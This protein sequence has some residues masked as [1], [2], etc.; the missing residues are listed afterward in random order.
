[1]KNDNIRTEISSS[2]KKQME[3]VTTISDATRQWLMALGMM[4]DLRSFCWATYDTHKK[5]G[6]PIEDHDREL[7]DALQAVET[8]IN[9]YLTCQIRISILGYGDPKCKNAI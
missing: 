9:K 5:L 8:V 6:Y 2:V 3:S 4:H 1:M 7:V